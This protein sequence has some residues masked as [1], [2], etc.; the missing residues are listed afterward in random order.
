MDTLLRFLGNIQ[1]MDCAGRAEAFGLL[2]FGCC[3]LGSWAD[4]YPLSV[5]LA[6]ALLTLLAVR[7]RSEPQLLAVVGFACYTSIADVVYL[8]S[9]GASVWGWLMA[10]ANIFLKLC[11]AANCFRLGSLGSDEELLAPGGGDDEPGGY[12]SARYH[13][14]GPG[15]GGFQQPPGAYA[16]PP[17]PGEYSAMAAEAADK[18][19]EATGSYRAI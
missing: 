4:D 15:G 6:I 8:L 9:E 17:T 11:A 16:A 13:E 1:H 7:C 19:A 3:V 2:S 10:A 5:N 14:P 12:P 18:L